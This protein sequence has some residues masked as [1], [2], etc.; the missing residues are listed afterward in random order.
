MVSSRKQLLKKVYLLHKYFFKMYS[1]SYPKVL[2]ET[3][4][5]RGFGTFC[6][7]TKTNLKRVR[8][9]CFREM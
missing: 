9:L 3:E 1:I 5:S 8:F 6:E 4:T 7:Q 2:D